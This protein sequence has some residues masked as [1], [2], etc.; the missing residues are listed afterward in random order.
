MPRNISRPGI[1]IRRTFRSGSI[2]R[3]GFG[4]CALRETPRD[5]SVAFLVFFQDQGLEIVSSSPER[6]IRKKGTLCETRPI[7]GTCKA[8]GSGRRLREW[9]QKLLQNP[10]ERAEHLMLVDLERND[11]GRVCD[12]RSVKVKEF[13]TLEKYSHVT[14]IVSKIT[15]RLRKGKDGS[16]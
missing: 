14:H 10:K 1:F 3:S 13:M 16:I 15:G 8:Y 12:Y 5:Q 11:L 6:L 2:S 7:A 4:V 9:R